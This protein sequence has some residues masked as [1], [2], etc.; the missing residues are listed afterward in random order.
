MRL[1]QALAPQVSS[2]TRSRGAVYFTSGAVSRIDV[3]DAILQARV[4]GSQPYDVCLAAAGTL[5][6][7]SC[8][9]PYYLD[10]VDICKHVWAALLAAEA[11]GIPLIDPGH[12]TNHLTIEPMDLDDPDDWYG[13]DEDAWR[14][15]DEDSFGTPAANAR[16]ERRPRATRPAWQHLLDAIV[17]APATAAPARPRLASGELLYVIDVEASLAA[18]EAVIDLMTR[19]QKANG[20]WGKPRPARVTAADIGTLAPGADRQ[21]LER[22]LGARPQFDWSAGYGEFGELSRVRLRGVLVEEI[23]PR[24]CATGRCMARVPAKPGSP[25]RDTVAPVKPDAPALLPLT[26]DDGPPWRLQVT[27]RRDAAAGAYVIDGSFTR[28]DQQMALAEPLLV[29]GDGML[30]TTTHAARLDH[31][32]AHTWLATLRRVASISVPFD[33]RPALIDALIAQGPPLA[34]VPDDLRV[35]IESGQPRAWLR[36]TPMRFRADR[37]EAEMLF[38]YDG[39]HVP[40]AASSP[41]VRTIDAS[42]IVARD[43]GAERTLLE[44]LYRLGFRSEWSFSSQERALQAPSHVLPRIV[45]TLLAEGWHV[46]AAGVTYRT[47]GNVAVHV[48][49][50]IDWFELTGQID[51]GGASVSLPS[52]LAAAARGDS[53]VTLDDGTL[54][55]LPEE[56]LRTHGMLARMGSVEGGRLRFRS[57]QVGLLDAL[58][59][60][61]P[62]ATCDEMFTRARGKL[63][64]F[65]GI[66]PA[67]PPAS[68]TGV[69]RGYQR[70]GLGWLLFLRE[71]GFGGCLADDMGLGKTVMVLALLA[72]RQADHTAGSGSR[73]TLVVAPRSLVF[74]W[75]RE[76][77]RFTP[78]LRVL[79]YT[80]AGRA[81][82]RERI[83]DHDVV[84]TTYGTL[85]RDAVHLASIPFEYV[86]LDEAQAIKNAAS[87]S[88]KAARLLNAEHRLALSGTPIE[89][90]HG[91]LWSLCEFLNPGLLGAAAAF[92]RAGTVR[93]MDAAAMAALAR[94]LRPFILRRTKDQ[95]APELPAKTEQTLYCELERPQRALYD[96]LRDHYR[97][98]LLGR[99][100]GALPGRTKL[101]V[102]EALL[103]LRQAACHPGLIDAKRRK[104]PSAKLDVLMP[105]IAQSVEE[106]HKTIVFSQFTSLL[107]LVRERLDAAGITYEY[108]DG[109]TRNRE[110]TVDRFQTHPDCRLFLIS[111]KAGGVGLNLTAAE[112]VFLLDPWWNPAVEAQAIDRTHRIGQVR[113][114]FA[115]RLIARDT[116]EERVL[117]LQQRK[118]A[119]ADAILSA[120]GGLMRD[121]RREDLELLLS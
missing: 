32:G 36:L 72:R 108:L 53:F 107:A 47:P 97:R 49:S 54:G 95:V 101:Q 35:T 60:D 92:E 120:D 18:G 87:A 90:H 38:D 71:F 24:A 30:V 52:L 9:C 41:V 114:V 88:A 103:R 44:R 105:H 55:L 21:I 100:S 15:A 66:A 102:L 43:F 74:N 110:A 109:R 12:A 45:R 69:L 2:R 118:R 112:Y 11:Q 99:V 84:L 34:Q 25:A 68:F 94:G 57:S 111:L 17:A 20:E 106:G 89:N 8:T 40:A 63:L 48:S 51:Y 119:L 93:S 79:E 16:S 5:L 46:E 80:G 81:A 31:G 26:A 61:Q 82:L 73:P 14:N 10:R 56:W 86:V 1:S 113:H 67:D 22:L 27:I 117:E 19:E 59:A 62:A 76:A 91:E 7:A 75:R 33:G 58:L 85:R 37:L 39:M 70:E 98:T 65:D 13:Q 78:H 77:S 23:L 50:G 83:L 96:E 64:S 28:E 104:D 3:R 115:Y 42:R 29:L 116:V 121:L 4:T 6:R